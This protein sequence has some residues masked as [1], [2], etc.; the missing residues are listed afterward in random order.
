MVALAPLVPQATHDGFRV[1]APTPWQRHMHKPP[2]GFRVQHP[3][4][5]V[6]CEA[7]VLYV[8]I[9]SQ[10]LCSDFP[11]TGFLLFL[12]QLLWTQYSPEIIQLDSLLCSAFSFRC[13]HFFPFPLFWFNF[14]L[15]RGVA[16]FQNSKL[17]RKIQSEAS[18]CPVSL[19]S[20]SL[21]PLFYTL[22]LPVFFCEEV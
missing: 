7:Q 9:W 14:W 13:K 4:A 8:R 6:L 18:F 10:I 2:L 17:Y 21:L 1:T 15:S 22:I 20:C 19:S 11:H 3:P 16:W 5:T 12:S